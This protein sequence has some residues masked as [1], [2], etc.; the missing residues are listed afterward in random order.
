MTLH[1]PNRH[2]D[3][4]GCAALREQLEAALI[5]AQTATEQWI[6]LR[7]ELDSRRAKVTA[8]MPSLRNEYGPRFGDL[9]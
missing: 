5:A 6:G 8:S 3:C 7:D 9:R 1:G 4:A 2:D